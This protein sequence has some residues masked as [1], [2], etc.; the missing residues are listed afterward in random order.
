MTVPA[1]VVVAGWTLA[2]LKALSAQTR[3][4]SAAVPLAPVTLDPC[5][6]AALAQRNVDQTDAEI[7]ELEVGGDLGRRSP[8]CRPVRSRREG[9]ERARA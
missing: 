9:P 4:V 3:L 8:S 7:V 2:V 1:A 5:N 6:F